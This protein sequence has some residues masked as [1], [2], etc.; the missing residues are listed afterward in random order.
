MRNREMRWPCDFP[1]TVMHG[2]DRMQGSI[3]NVSG[4]GA[5]LRLAGEAPIGEVVT[6]D[7]GPRRV[8]ATVRWSRAGMCGLR[9]LTPLEKKELTLI[10]R[11]HATVSAGASGRWNAHLRELR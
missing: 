2:K 7:I 4:G 6:L 10:R 1:V 3:I 8:A 5:R 11:G 9:L